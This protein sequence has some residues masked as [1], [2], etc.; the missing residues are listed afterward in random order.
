MWNP[1][2]VYVDDSLPGLVYLEHLL[3]VEVSE[4]LVALRIASERNPLDLPI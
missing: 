1:T 4:H 2:L 3:C